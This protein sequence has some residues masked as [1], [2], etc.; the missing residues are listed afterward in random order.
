MKTI[1]LITCSNAAQAHI[2]QGALAN[3]GIDSVLHNENFSSLL[4]GFVDYISGVD[5]LVDEEDYAEAIRVLKRNQAWPDEFK[6]CPY[7]GSSNIKFVLKKKN[8]IRAIGAAVFAALASIPPGK[9]HWE[10]ICR[11]CDRDFEMPVSEF[12]VPEKDE[13]LCD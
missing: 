13:E 6:L 8:R 2:L 7:C 12:P 9:N 5:I 3:E 11:E 1:R 10:Y 4:V